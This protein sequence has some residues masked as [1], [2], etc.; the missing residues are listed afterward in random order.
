M[1]E[2]QFDLA[3]L[4]K[5]GTIQQKQKEY[6]VLRLRLV[7]GDVT[8]EEMDKV[9]SIAREYGR[10]DIHLTTRQGIEIPFVHYTKAEAARIAIEASGLKMGACGP[11]F[12]VII[13]CPGNS[14]CKWGTINTKELA[15]ELDE[16][17]FGAE[18]PHKFKLAITG[19]PHNCAKST[20]N[21]IGIMGAILPAWKEDSCNDCRLCINICPTRALE[22]I[23]MDDKK[24]KYI[25]REDKCINC[26]ICTGSCPS[27][28]WVPDKAGY[29]M[30]IGGTMGKIPR[31]GTILKKFITDKSELLKLVDRS[32][33]YYQKNGRKKERF[34][35]MIDRIGVEKVNQEILNGD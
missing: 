18:T 29:N 5:V 11:R 3:A 20:E 13:A 27:N 35:H 25:L 12:R 34:G 30:T 6:F 1:S 32:I 24:I 26:S 7:G 22:R 2:L 31:L 8:A 15:K 14:I 10:G 9:N 23:E 19:C 17:Y 4:K 28:S 33:S 21:D 16:K